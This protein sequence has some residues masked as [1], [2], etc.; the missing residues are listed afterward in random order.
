MK[1]QWNHKDTEATETT[2]SKG[3]ETATTGKQQHRIQDAERAAHKANKEA[4]Q[5]EYNKKSSHEVAQH[6]KDYAGAGKKNKHA[7]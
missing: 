5:A 1:K 4:A 7:K 2:A 3:H 6:G